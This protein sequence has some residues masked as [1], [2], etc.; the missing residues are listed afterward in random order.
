MQAWDHFIAQAPQVIV[1]KVG[2]G[3]TSTMGARAVWPTPHKFGTTSV[4]M[5]T[6]RQ[7]SSPCTTV[8][9]LAMIADAI[10][11]SNRGG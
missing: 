5:Q 7:A 3:H 9:P 10:R 4:R 8:K 11:L 1:F 6:E 2:K